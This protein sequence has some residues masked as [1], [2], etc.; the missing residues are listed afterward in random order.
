MNRQI[1]CVIAVSALFGLANGAV[2]QPSDAASEQRTAIPSSSSGKITWYGSRFNGRKTASGER[3]NANAMTMAHKT[4]PF[5]T[6]VRVTDLK[7][8]K[9]VV[10]RVNDRGPSSPDLIGDVTSSEARKLGMSRSGVI[11]AKLE[12]VGKA[13]KRVGNRS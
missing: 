5:G 6:K 4:L 9:S 11:E 3:F 13:P 10:L 2:A 12:V 7:N 1:L 8:N